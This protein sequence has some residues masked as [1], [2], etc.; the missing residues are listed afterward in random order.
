MKS[1]EFHAARVAAK[2]WFL[3]H[4][5][6][7]VFKTGVNDVARKTPVVDQH[8]PILVISADVWGT[9]CIV[10][11]SNCILSKAFSY[12]AEQIAWR[13]HC[14]KKQRSLHSFFC[15]GNTIFSSIGRTSGLNTQ[16]AFFR[17]IS[18][19][20]LCG[21]LPAKNVCICFSPEIISFKKRISEYN[22][23]LDDQ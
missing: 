18:L 19:L 12:I 1:A 6:L 5:D 9:C 2:E 16:G 22:I 14:A 4:V 8:F 23:K 15:S 13:L 10:T 20:R 7:I 3:K 11:G 17:R 21:N